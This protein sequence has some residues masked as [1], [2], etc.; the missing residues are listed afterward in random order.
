MTMAASIEG[1]VPFCDHRVLELAN[2]LPPHLKANG[3]DL[4]FILKK[5]AEQ[6]LPPELIHREKM[7]F[8]LPIQKWFSEQNTLQCKINWLEEGRFLDKK[9][10]DPDQFL[11]WRKSGNCEAQE[12]DDILWPLISYEMWHREFM[13]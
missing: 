10:I 2:T 1:R 8:S 5:V 9:I 11:A 3:N 7:G 6:Y 4:K 12:F 13:A